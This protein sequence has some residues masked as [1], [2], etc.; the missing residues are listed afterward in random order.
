[1]PWYTRWKYRFIVWFFDKPDAL[2]RRVRIEQ[3]LA[4]A[5]AGKRPLPTAEECAQWADELGVPTALQGTGG[6]GNA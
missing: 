6:E 2:A 4:N 1:M 5:A 3:R